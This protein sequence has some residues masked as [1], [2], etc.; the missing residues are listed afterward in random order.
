MKTLPAIEVPGKTESERF[1]NAM[2]QIL[3]VPKSELDKRKEEWKREQDERKAGKTHT[4]EG[5]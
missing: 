4:P 5:Q 2:R 3:S 1:E